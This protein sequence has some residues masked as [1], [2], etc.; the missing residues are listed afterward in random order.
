[1]KVHLLLKN[2]I[3]VGGTNFNSSVLAVTHKTP[4]VVIFS[5]GTGFIPLSPSPHHTERAFFTTYLASGEICGKV[6]FRQVMS[7]S[8][9][10]CISTIFNFKKDYFVHPPSVLKL[11]D[12]HWKMVKIWQIICCFSVRKAT[13]NHIPRFARETNVKPINLQIKRWNFH[14]PRNR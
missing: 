6:L 1:M 7:E 10:K 4:C 13:K 11:T 14:C 3:L 9:K 8:E 5:P 12:S 2:I